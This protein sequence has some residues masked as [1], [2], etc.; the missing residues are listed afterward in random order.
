[1]STASH[2]YH[3]LRNVWYITS[4]AFFFW[5]T[6]ESSYN[7]S[8]KI[9][10]SLF[11]ALVC[12]KRTHTT[13]TMYYHAWSHC[14]ARASS[15]SSTRWYANNASSHFV[16][17]LPITFWSTRYRSF[18]FSAYARNRIDYKVFSIFISFFFLFF[19][20]QPSSV[21]RILSNARIYFVKFHSLLSLAFIYFYVRSSRPASL[22]NSL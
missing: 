1:M 2:L 10:L 11:L 16:L 18:L 7:R 5:D 6:R 19:F 8:L 17:P 14:S 3:R 4:S 20:S 12:S 21:C 13:G 15:L 9:S 22:R